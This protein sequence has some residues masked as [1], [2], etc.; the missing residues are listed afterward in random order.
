M[1]GTI[2]RIQS[3][4]LS[5]SL[6]F[7]SALEHSISEVQENQT[8]LKLNRTHEFLAYANDVNILGDDINT[9]KKSTE[10]EILA[11]KKVSI[12]INVER[13]NFMLNAICLL[14]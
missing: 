13:A 10:S 4:L 6:H 2:T 5:L 3:L 7:I 9:M 8:G 12:E 1:V 11:S 14:G